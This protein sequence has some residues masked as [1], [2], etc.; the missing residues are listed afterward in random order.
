MREDGVGLAAS[1]YAARN[2]PVILPDSIDDH[3]VEPRK[4][5]TQPVLKRRRIAIRGPTRAA[6]MYIAVQAILY[7]RIGH[8]RIRE[9]CVWTVQRGNFHFIAGP[10]MRLHKHAHRLRRASP[11]GVQCVDHVQQTHRLMVREWIRPRRKAAWL[12]SRPEYK[13]G[14]VAEQLFLGPVLQLIGGI[15]GQILPAQVGILRLFFK[16]LEVIQE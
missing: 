2:Q 8:C 4:V 1:Q 11:F 6:G 16:Y 15:G 9:R 10:L 7:R 3:A 5:G 13:K 14:L 12:P